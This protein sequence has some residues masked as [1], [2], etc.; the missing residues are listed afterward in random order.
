MY[1]VELDILSKRMA[2][3]ILCPQDRGPGRECCQ[4]RP[5]GAGLLI[6][7]LLMVYLNALRVGVQSDF[8][9]LLHI[10]ENVFVFLKNHVLHLS[11]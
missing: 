1:S 6:C 8:H 3:D 4:P 2:G 10:L 11:L 7:S 9:L 5:S